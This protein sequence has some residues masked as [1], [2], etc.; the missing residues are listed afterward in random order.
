M[1]DPVT[2]HVLAKVKKKSLESWN[3]PGSEA[4]ASGDRVGIQ[5]LWE[6]GSH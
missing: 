5:E 3:P 2:N 6:V 4:E 1:R